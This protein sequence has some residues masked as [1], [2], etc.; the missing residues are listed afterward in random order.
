[1]FGFG[2][3][4]CAPFKHRGSEAPK[5]VAESE[6]LR[7]EE[8]ARVPAATAEEPKAPVRAEDAES[9]SPSEQGDQGREEAKEPEAHFGRT[10]S[11]P[12]EGNEPGGL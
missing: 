3:A 12:W 9:H 7:M 6:S 2:S 4:I 11:N 1:M 8:E 5:K 10:N